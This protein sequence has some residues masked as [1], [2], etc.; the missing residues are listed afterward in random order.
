MDSKLSYDEFTN[1]LANHIVEHFPTDHAPVVA[2]LNKKI[3]SNDQTIDMLTIRTIGASV[4]PSL[5]VNDIYEHYVSNDI[6]V[7][8]IMDEMVKQYT[9]EQEFVNQQKNIVD[10]ISDFEKIKSQIMPRLSNRGMSQEFLNG[11]VVFPVE[12]L[13]LTFF[14]DLG[15]GIVNINEALLGVWNVSRE[16]LKEIALANL[17]PQT[18]GLMKLVDAI[19]SHCS[20]EEREAIEGIP[21]FDIYKM[22]PMY[23]IASSRDDYGAAGMLCKPLMDSLCDMFDGDVLIIPSSADE[24]I[25]MPEALGISDI[26]EIIPDINGEF[27]HPDKVLSNHAYR[28]SKTEGLS[29]IMDDD[30]ESHNQVS[31]D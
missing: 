22:L 19:L 15:G 11:K 2:M 4:A 1:Y 9:S 13:A 12:D 10:Q 26:N 27:V 23:V 21:D 28:Y 30:L 24:V 25:V 14:I 8:A 7:D 6:S 18:V 3:C 5:H 20:P 16:T 29:S 17:T 31:E